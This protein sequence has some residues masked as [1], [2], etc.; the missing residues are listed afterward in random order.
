[1]HNP[2]EDERKENHSTHEMVRSLHERFTGFEYRLDELSKDH[3]ELKGRVDVVEKDVAKDISALEKHESEAC[4]REN[5]IVN[6][7][8]Q[9]KEAFVAHA[10][11]EE[12]DRKRMFWVLVSVVISMVGGFSGVALTILVKLGGVA[13]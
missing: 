12:E 9:L 1:M 10:K 4:L 6:S 2:F 13:G 11:Q 3:K 8:N 5:S 7:H